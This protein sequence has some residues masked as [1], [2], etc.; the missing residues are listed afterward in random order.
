MV[1]DYKYLRMWPFN[2][3]T[4]RLKGG[5]N[6]IQV[7]IGPRQVGKT[8]A[9][10][11]YL[12]TLKMPFIYDTADLLSPPSIGWIEESWKKARFIA[13]E[14]GSALLVLDEIQKVVRWSEAVKKFH[15]EDVFD[16]SRLRVVLLGS[17]ALMVQMG[18]KESLAG[19]FETIP[20]S[21]WSYSECAE[22]FGLDLNEYVFFGGYPG[23]ISIYKES[24]D[25]IRWQRY[26]R[27]SLIET[28]IGKDILMM[29]SIEK[30]ALFRQVFQLSCAHPAET[31]PFTKM[32]GQLQDTGN[33]TII[34][35]YLNIMKAAGLIVPLQKYSGSVIKQRA[36]SPKLLV[37]NSALINA[38]MGRMFEETV[39]NEKL[40]GL[41]V[42]NAAGAY[43]YNQ[44]APN[45]VEVF[46][47]RD[48]DDEVD[49]VL[50]RGDKVIGIEIKSGKQKPGRGIHAFKRAYKEATALIVGGS[51]ADIELEAFFKT[52]PNSLF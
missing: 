50:K 40:W 22:A 31:I 32:L 21:H 39:K 44:L 3:L 24:K 12:E 42:E 9:V 6:L 7:V 38:S 36:S 16:G 29:T 14:K 18:L 28:V 35:S 23:A 52:D 11:Q 13:D 10:R 43:L 46:Y 45:G 49:Y 26:V 30:P 47:W 34:S 33:A 1:M 15:D 51:G 5:K 25:I 17:S 19:R 20:F 4:E 48:R 41:L 37:L 27:D 8:T 2:G